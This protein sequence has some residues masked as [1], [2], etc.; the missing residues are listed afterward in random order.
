MADVERISVQDARSRVQSGEAL[1]VCAYDNEEKFG[2]LHLEGALAFSD[3]RSK[4]DS[5]QK[6]REI[7]F[8]CA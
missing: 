8:Y 1:L 5:L 4:A 2:S 6:A 7:I 3:F